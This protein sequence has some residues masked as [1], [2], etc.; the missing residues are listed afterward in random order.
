MSIVSN[1]PPVTSSIAVIVVSS[2]PIVRGAQLAD[3][4]IGRTESRLGTPPVNILI[5][6][7]RQFHHSHRLEDAL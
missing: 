5:P 1:C 4:L 6:L 7:A 3:L 2:T